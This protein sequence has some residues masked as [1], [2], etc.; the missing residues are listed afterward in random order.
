MRRLLMMALVP[1]L[2]AVGFA[3]K[4]KGGKV[5]GWVQAAPAHCSVALSVQ[6]GWV[7]DHQ[8]VQALMARFPLADQMLDLFLKKARINPQG[9]TGRVTFYVLDLPQQDQRDLAEAARHFLV[10]L[11]GF[12]DPAAIQ[13]AVLEA[14]PQE[15]S[16]S[17]QAKD[18]P[19]HVLMDLN[20]NHFRAALEPGGRIWLG[21]LV[22]LGRIAAKNPAKRDLAT[23]AAEWVD[24]KAPF[25]GM[26]QVAPLLDQVRGHLPKNLGLDIPSGVDTLAWSVTPSNDAKAPHRLELAVTGTQE[27]I[28]Q[29]APWLQ[30]IG[31]LASAAGPGAAQPPEIITERTRAGLRASMTQEQLN[32]VLSKLGQ[33]PLKFDKPSMGPKA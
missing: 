9:E 26:I 10:L 24:G 27:A 5:P 15:G 4:S 1:G 30:R 18:C 21:D 25:Q 33:M 16:M 19:L 11:D 12:K 28:T 8:N 6:A 31:A 13:A 29:V 2:I 17:I 14:F 7:L 3:C 23:K 20:Q 22:A 32:A